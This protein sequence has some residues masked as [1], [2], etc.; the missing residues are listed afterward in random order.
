MHRFVFLILILLLTAACS[1]SNANSGEL[2]SGDAARG[3]VLF[4]ESVNGAPACTTCHT[5]DGSTL[6]GPSLQ[7]F[8]QRAGNRVEGQSAEVYAHN[9]I[10]QPPAYIVSGFGN[11]MYN[12]YAQRLTP[13]QIADLVAYILTL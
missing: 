3:Q 9:S 4:N 13:Q 11:L 10:Q 1:T 6:V 5:T 2:P 12:Q 8:G 7:G